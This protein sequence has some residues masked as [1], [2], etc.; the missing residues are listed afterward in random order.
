ME[1]IEPGVN[2]ITQIQI[3]NSSG[4]VIDDFGYTP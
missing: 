3:I 1:G 2:N 4:V